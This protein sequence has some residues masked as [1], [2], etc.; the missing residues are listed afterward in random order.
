MKRA[1][2]LVT[3]AGRTDEGIT[4]IWVAMSGCIDR[5]L[6]MDG[7]LPGGLS[8]KRRAKKILKQLQGERGSNRSAARRVRLAQRLRDGRQ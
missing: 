7:I 2:E 3:P 1:N 5:G 6:A 8:V 4:R